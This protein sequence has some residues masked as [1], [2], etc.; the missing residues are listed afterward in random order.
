[1]FVEVAFLTRIEHVAIALHNFVIQAERGLRVIQTIL[2]APAHHNGVVASALTLTNSLKHLIVLAH[3][4][5]SLQKSNCSPVITDVIRHGHIKSRLA[6]LASLIDINTCINE[7]LAGK[8]F[9]G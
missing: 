7:H 6:N 8:G 2:L 1:V 9:E 3:L 5:P 4:S